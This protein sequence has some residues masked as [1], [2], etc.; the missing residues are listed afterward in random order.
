MADIEHRLNAVEEIIKKPSFRENKGLSNEVGYYVFDYPA[1]QELA[2]RDR[3]KKIAKKHEKGTYGFKLVIFD[4]YEVIISMLEEKKFL[5]KCFDFEKTKGFSHITKS[6]ESAF[7]FSGE[8][9]LLVEYIKE[10]TPDSSVVFLTGIGKCYPILRSHN[11]LNNLH[12]VMDKVPVV[13]FY[14]GKYDGQEL[15]L[16]SELKDHNYYRAFRLVD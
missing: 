14:P 2:V 3:I 9:N 8:K 15:I 6:I 12:Q 5:E 10:N 7:R 4:L 16:F 11:I 1:D 13:M